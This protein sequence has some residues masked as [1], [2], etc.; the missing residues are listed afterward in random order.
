MA[1]PCASPVW[2]S[3]GEIAY[4]GKTGR[5]AYTRGLEH[6]RALESRKEDKS[7]TIQEGNQ[8]CSYIMS[9]VFA[10]TEILL[11]VEVPKTWKKFLK[12]GLQR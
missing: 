3:G 11:E 5:N 9:I 12:T 10:T 6:L 2:A 4:K 7:T 8:I 1:D